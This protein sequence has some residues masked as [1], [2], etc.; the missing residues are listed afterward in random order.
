M[1]NFFADHQLDDV[2]C[3]GCEKKT[4]FTQKYRFLTFPKTL[5]VVLQRF[6]FDDWVPKKLEIEL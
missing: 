2:W 1:E 3:A 6:V 4:T 5:V